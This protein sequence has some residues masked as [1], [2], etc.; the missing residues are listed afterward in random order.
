MASSL[1]VGATPTTLIHD[2]DHEMPAATFDS[3]QYIGNL[4]SHKS[5]SVS[6]RYVGMMNPGNKVSF[7]TRDEAI[8][9]GYILC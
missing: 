9:N 3:G 8:G 2:H 6:C 5:H 7:E 1:I 4:N